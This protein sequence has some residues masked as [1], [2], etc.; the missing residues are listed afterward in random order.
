MNGMIWFICSGIISVCN[1]MLTKLLGTI[2][3]GSNILFFRLLISFIT[4]IPFWL[5]NIT[6]NFKIIFLNLLRAILLF[7]GMLQWSYGAITL[8]LSITTT[9]GFTTPISSTIL[10]SILLKESFSKKYMVANIIGF[11]GVIFMTLNDDLS[12]NHIN[13][14]SIL[15]L[16][17]ATIC[18]VLLDI[19]NKKM[20]LQNESIISMMFYSS[21]FTL[22]ISSIFTIDSISIEKIHFNSILLLIMLG[23]GA[24]LILFCLLK[25]FSYSPIFKLQPLKYLELVTAMILSIIIFNEY[26]NIMN[27]IGTCIII[28]TALYSALQ[29]TQS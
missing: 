14:Y 25:A 11:I 3:N 21:F 20:L 28:P 27:I 18:F 10:A 15:Y 4:I 19:L 1:D 6:F 29:K 16:M 22:I 2:L 24:N 13:L 12:I 23:I 17:S 8:P 7:I 26:M 9:I 5:Y